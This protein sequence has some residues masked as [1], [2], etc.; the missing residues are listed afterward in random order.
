[1]KTKNGFTL[2]ELIIAFSIFLIVMGLV[3][4]AI[5]GVFRSSEQMQVVLD[6]EQRQRACFLR[7]S[8]EIS[9]LARIEYPK[10]RFKGG[11]EEFYFI[12]AREDSLVESRYVFEASTGSLEH[13]YQEPANYDWQTNENKQVC[14]DGLSDCKFSYSDGQ[15][16]FD[17]WDQNNDELPGLIKVSFKFKGEDSERE[18]IAQVPVSG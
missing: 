3:L 14:L 11:Q 17:S 10:H 12:F 1:M 18:F 6:K 7:L 16:W 9:S 13:Y 5:T 4:A 2:V 8:R 15:A